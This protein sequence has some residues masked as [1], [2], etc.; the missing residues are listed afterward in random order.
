MLS[1][2]VSIDQHGFISGKTTA[3]NHLVFQKYIVDA[4][5]SSS[6]V[7][8]IYTH[9]SKAFDKVNHTLLL[10][11]LH[12]IGI[13]GSVLSWISSYVLS[14][15]TQIVKYKNFIS[16]PFNVPSGVPQRSHLGPLLFLLF[17][18]DINFS[19]S[20]KLLFADDL[21]LFRIFNSSYDLS[22]LQI[23]LNIL[24]NWCTVNKLPLNVEKC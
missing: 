4:F 1:S 10:S 14:N 17:I 8:F 5:A 22:L 6:Q 24:S 13:C 21:K 9:F 20:R 2:S 15:R 3:T 16:N 19:N 12:T 7:D 18:N 11:K 23:D